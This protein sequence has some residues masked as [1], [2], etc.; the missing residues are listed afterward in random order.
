MGKIIPMSRVKGV[1]ASLRKKKKK[2]VTTNGVFDILHIGHITYLQKARALGDVLIVGLNTD[3]S[4]RKLKGPKRPIVSEKARAFCLAALECVDYVVIFN[5]PTP[6]PL[7]SLIEPDFHVKGGDYRGKEV[8]IVEKDLIERNGG[9]VVLLD[10]VRG[11][12]TTKLI[13]KISDEYGK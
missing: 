2:I 11:Y 6:I 9:K 5:D 10:L 3:E 7:L 4:V 12:S 13:E 8:K 1:V